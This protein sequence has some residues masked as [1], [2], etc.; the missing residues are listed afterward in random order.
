MIGIGRIS[1][2]R[3]SEPFR[4]R[5]RFGFG[6]LTHSSTDSASICLARANASVE[7]CIANAVRR[8][9]F[10]QPDGGMPVGVN[11]P[12]LLTSDQ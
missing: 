1:A 2:E 4:V 12:F 3:E 9:S 7:S 5:T 6:V 10:P 11:Y 8:W